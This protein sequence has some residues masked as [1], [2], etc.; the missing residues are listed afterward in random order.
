MNFD[1][2]SFAIGNHGDSGPVRDVVSYLIGRMAGT[3]GEIWQ[4]ITNVAVASFTAVSS[5]LRD[6]V[7]DVTPMQSGS[8]DPSP[9]NVRPITGWTGANIYDA[10][11]NLLDGVSLKQGGITGYGLDNSSNTRVR[12]A[13]IPISASTAYSVAIGA[14]GFVILAVHY[15]SSNNTSSWISKDAP[16]G[17][18]SS[19]T[20]PATAA[21]C[22]LNLSRTDTSANVTPSDI[23][24]KRF[25]C[26]SSIFASASVSWQTEVGTVY[27][28][29]LTDNGDGTWTLKA[30][31]YYAS[32][33][34]ETLVGPWVSSMDV[35][36]EGMS[37]TAGAQVVDLGG[38]ETA[39]TITAESVQAL[40]GQNNIFA[41]V[42]S[43]NT[44]TF[45]TN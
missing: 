6:L 5:T 14:A 25:L 32:Y 42:G 13:Y 29:T 19:F 45:R 26:R 16:A 8:G 40:I 38:A 36:V 23:P 33:N 4:T 2:L 34:G 7:I 1:S 43:I 30:R 9:S 41:D 37:P 12:T 21:F 39:Y 3:A 20:T 10:G 31:P 44:I 35:Y 22:R 24:D 28:G 11:E 17:G 27:G 18:V 15:Y